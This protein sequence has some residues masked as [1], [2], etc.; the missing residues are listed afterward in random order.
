MESYCKVLLKNNAKKHHKDAIIFHLTAMRN[1]DSKGSH[2]MSFLHDTKSLYVLG[3]LLG[4]LK[5]AFYQNQ[6]KSIAQNTQQMVRGAL[7]KVDDAER[8]CEA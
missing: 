4:Q 6:E 5:H 2:A 1:Y 3:V 7:L 8:K